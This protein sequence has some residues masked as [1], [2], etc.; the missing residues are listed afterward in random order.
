MI[1][2]II[3]IL[4]LGTMA[5]SLSDADIERRVSAAQKIQLNIDEATGPRISCFV[6][7]YTSS[8]RLTQR[9]FLATVAVHCCLFHGTK[10]YSKGA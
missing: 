2:A 4:N 7:D 3:L 5:M 10:G 9:V 6:T 8:S 1:I